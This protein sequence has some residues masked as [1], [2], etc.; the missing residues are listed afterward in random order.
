M[1]GDLPIDKVT[2]SDVLAVLRP[3]WTTKIEAGRKLR[4]ENPG[5]LCLLAMAHGHIQVNP[6]G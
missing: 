6:A 2:R 1:I 3:I 4:P 5:R